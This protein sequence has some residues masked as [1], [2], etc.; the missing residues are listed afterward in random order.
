MAEC[1]NRDN[2]NDDQSVDANQTQIPMRFEGTGM[3]QIPM[4]FL[5]WN[6]GKH[7]G[8]IQKGCNYGKFV[9]QTSSTL[10]RFIVKNN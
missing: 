10:T 1:K 7:E 8:S 2:S 6:Y 4:R 3:R 5:F 9:N